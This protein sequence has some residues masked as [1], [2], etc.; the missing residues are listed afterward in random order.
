MARRGRG[1]AAPWRVAPSPPDLPRASGCGG[2]VPSGRGPGMG[3]ATASRSDPELD[4]AAADGVARGE[5]ELL[6]AVLAHVPAGIAVLEVPGY[7]FAL[8]NPAYQALA[9]ERKF[10]GNT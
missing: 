3:G 4:G 6:G 1:G 5:H 2:L 8:V 9:P 7:R 10:L